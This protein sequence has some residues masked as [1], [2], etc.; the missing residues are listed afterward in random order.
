MHACM[1]SHVCCSV[2]EQIGV[3]VCVCVCVDVVS[4]RV[5]ICVH[6]EVGDQQ[7]P[8]TRPKV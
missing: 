5:L 2:L 4:T 6:N 3:G 1:S 7:P 8:F